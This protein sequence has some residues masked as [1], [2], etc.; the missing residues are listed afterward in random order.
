M[1]LAP[2]DAG[3]GFKFFHKDLAKIWNILKFY[4]W[5]ATPLIAQFFNFFDENFKHQ[6]LI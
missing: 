4:F 1:S 3:E 2:S 5:Q 6:K